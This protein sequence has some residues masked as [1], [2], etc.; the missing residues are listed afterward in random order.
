MLP[1][2]HPDGVTM[3][4]QTL[5]LLPRASQCLS[6]RNFNSHASRGGHC[7]AIEYADFSIEYLDEARW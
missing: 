5:D 2:T 4:A 3:P 1:T 6:G 7:V